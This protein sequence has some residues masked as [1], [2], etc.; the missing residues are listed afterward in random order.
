MKSAGLPLDKETANVF[1]LKW[2]NDIANQRMHATTGS[3]PFVRLTEEQESL[4]SLVPPY[5]PTRTPSPEEKCCIA[6]ESLEKKDF[7]HALTMYEQLFNPE[8]VAA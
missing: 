3:V 5:F 2:L 7:Q 8:G 1:V 6:Y 4:Q